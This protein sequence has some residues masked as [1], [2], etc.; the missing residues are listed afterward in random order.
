MPHAAAPRRQSSGIRLASTSEPHHLTLLNL[1]YEEAK[2]PIKDL[3]RLQHKRYKIPA[4]KLSDHTWD[5]NM[6]PVG[7]Q[8]IQHFPYKHSSNSLRISLYELNKLIIKL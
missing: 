7:Q 4:M 3:T 2:S 5:R 8:V 1:T 6:D